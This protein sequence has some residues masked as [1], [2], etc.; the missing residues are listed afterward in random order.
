MYFCFQVCG[1][2]QYGE[3]APQYSPNYYSCPGQLPPSLDVQALDP[4]EEENLWLASENAALKGQNK[5]FPWSGLSWEEEKRK[6]VN[7][8]KTFHKTLGRKLFMA[9]LEVNRLGM[10]K[11]LGLVHTYTGIF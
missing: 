8:S 10:E 7:E 6:L 5:T 11:A 3:A 1:R 9:K 4:V 2:V